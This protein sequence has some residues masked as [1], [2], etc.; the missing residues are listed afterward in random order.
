MGSEFEDT[1]FSASS[2]RVCLE[3]VQIGSWKYTS[4]DLEDIEMVY[5]LDS[6]DLLINTNVSGA[7]NDA[8]P[9]TYCIKNVSAADLS[10]VSVIPGSLESMVT[11]LV[12]ETDRK[13]S[14]VSHEDVLK[15]GN[16][17]SED[18]DA[19]HDLNVHIVHVTASVHETGHLR[20]ILLFLKCNYQDNLS[21]D[22]PFFRDRQTPA[23]RSEEDTPGEVTKPSLMLIEGLP[24]W[25]SHIPWM[26]YS[27]K[28][29]HLLQRIL[30]FYTV[31]S[32]LWAMWQLYRHVNVIRVVIQPIMTALKYYLSPVV[33]L[34]DFAFAIFT[35]WWHTFLSPLNVLSSLLLSPMLQVFRNFQG[36]LSPLCLSVIHIFQSTGV[37]G[38]VTSLFSVLYTL[39]RLSSSAIW[40][41]FKVILK[42][43]SFVWQSVLSS[44]IAVAS[45]DFQ[46]LRLSWV[47]NLILSS[48]RQII[49]GLTTFVGYTWKEKK[50]KKAM[51][52]SSSTPLV[53]PISSPPGSSR[54]RRKNMPIVYSSPLSKQH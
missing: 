53:S 8:V 34:C 6:S 47:F 41:L 17:S 29:R 13:I 51:K 44:R 31:I 14:Y 18:E 25:V 39:V 11:R 43:L 49:K 50:I 52:G 2:L 40:M 21:P 3:T 42:P 19:S 37:I 27:K 26:F 54:R 7:V 23:K 24:Y 16:G 30:F 32:V 15:G 35:L 28:A 10:L 46:R 12:L 33:D 48:F 4:K 45:L 38:A 1:D 22:S 20:D 9:A 36:V 5:E